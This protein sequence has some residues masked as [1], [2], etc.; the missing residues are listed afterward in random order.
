MQYMFRTLSKGL[1]RQVLDGDLEET[2]YD[3]PSSEEGNTEEELEGQG[4]TPLRETGRSRLP[5]NG[6]CYINGG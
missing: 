6:V 5:C 1:R 2:R 3:W 4:R